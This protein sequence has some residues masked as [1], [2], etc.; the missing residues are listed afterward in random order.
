[1][2]EPTNKQTHTNQTKPK[3]NLTMNAM[4]EWITI[5]FDSTQRNT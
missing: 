3:T 5:S 2:D 4:C 1:M